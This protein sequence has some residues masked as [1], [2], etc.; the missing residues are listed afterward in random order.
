MGEGEEYTVV[1]LIVVEGAE[2]ERAEGRGDERMEE[3]EERPPP[4]PPDLAL[5]MVSV[6]KSKLGEA[7]RASGVVA[8]EE[9]MI[10]EAT[11]AVRNLVNLFSFFMLRAVVEC[12]PAGTGTGTENAEAPE[13][14]RNARRAETLTILLNLVIFS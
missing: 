6:P 9:R 14:A 10:A 5:I 2:Y 8:A 13:I 11:D 7:A 1:R 3:P 12:F 4:L